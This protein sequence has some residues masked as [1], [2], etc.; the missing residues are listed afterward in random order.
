MATR[1]EKV[2]AL[3]NLMQVSDGS[4]A[5]APPESAIRDLRGPRSQVEVATKSGL[6][7][8]T[9]SSMERGDRSLTHEIALKLAPA[10][11]TTVD[12]LETAEQISSLQRE[13]AEGKL[14]PRLLVD[15]VLEIAGTLPDSEASDNLTM[16]LVE[17]LRKALESFETDEQEAAASRIAT[18]SSQRRASRDSLGRR[19]DKPFATGG[20]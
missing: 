8:T 7:Q 15:T 18:K 10:L 1:S 4:K 9:I 20:S 13:A 3:I 16:A 19:R 5:A 12:E 6:A 17:V 11:D 14:D 2:E